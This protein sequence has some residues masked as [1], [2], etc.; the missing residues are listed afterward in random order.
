MKNKPIK[1]RLEG[2]SRDCTRFVDEI[3][4]I[5]KFK[6]WCVDLLTHGARIFAVS[7]FF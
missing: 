7:G 1:R 4:Y 3:E 2:E 5:G 6:A